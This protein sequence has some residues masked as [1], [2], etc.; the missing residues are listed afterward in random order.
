MRVPTDRPLAV[1]IRELLADGDEYKF[2]KSDE[3]LDLRADIL[4][5]QHN[6]CEMC[7]AK[8]VYS[9]AVTV[10][11][12]NEIRDRPDL[13]LSVTFI[14]GQGRVQRNLIALCFDCHNE[15]HN[16]FKGGW[17]KKKEKPLTEE[18]WD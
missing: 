9:R 5:K 16:R 17:W 8:G 4:D 10:H 3:W 14:D 12:V 1:W 7:K 18:R 6:E 2:Y 11:H 15:V 13:A